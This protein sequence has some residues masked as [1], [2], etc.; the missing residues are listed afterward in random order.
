MKSKNT[1]NK[2]VKDFS[3]G[4]CCKISNVMMRYPKTYSDKIYDAVTIHEG[5]EEV[6]QAGIRQGLKLAI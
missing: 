1:V 2:K 4:I 3:D 5:I 6:H